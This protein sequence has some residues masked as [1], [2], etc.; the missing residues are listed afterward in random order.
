MKY[1]RKII[2]IC[3]IVIIA[4]L[5][6]CTGLILK[7]TSENPQLNSIPAIAVP[8]A[9]I[10]DTTLLTAPDPVY[11]FVNH[12]ADVESRFKKPEL[13]DSTP[14]VELSKRDF[15]P[16]TEEYFA[17]A[18]FIGDSRLSL[19]TIETDGEKGWTLVTYQNLPLGW[20]KVSGGQLKNHLPKGL[21]LSLHL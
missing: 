16:V 19:K 6:T 9:V 8:F 21:R 1:N 11:P 18:L 17:D 10:Q 5:L 13:K 3:A 7:R 15:A 14:E 12:T 20:G 2:L 4:I